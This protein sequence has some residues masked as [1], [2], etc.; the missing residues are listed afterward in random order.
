MR[1]VLQAKVQVLCVAMGALLAWWG[2]AMPAQAQTDSLAVP[3]NDSLALVMKLRQEPLTIS[4]PAKAAL[5]SAV[6]PGLGQ[7]HNK[8]LWYIKVPV[9]YGG[10][11][12][13]VWYT[14]RNHK[15]FVAYRNA[16]LYKLDGNPDTAVDPRYSTFTDDGLRSRRDRFRRERDY[17]IILS[18]G[19]YLLQIAEA[20]TTAH[21]KSFDISDELALKLRPAVLPLGGQIG[22]GL[23]LSLHFKHK[24]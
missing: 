3:I 10:F 18:L 2:A 16:Y 17:S 1:Q 21:L 20:A 15:E 7:Y 23:S 12:F 13:L 6:L 22:G 9:I 24:P 8:K 11:G 19:F 14:A 4:E 5:L